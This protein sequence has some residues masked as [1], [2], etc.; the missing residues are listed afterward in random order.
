MGTHSGAQFCKWCLAPV[1]G[2]VTLGLQLVNEFDPV[3]GDI[4]T[5]DDSV[6]ELA[7]DRAFDAL[8]AVPA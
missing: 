7:S 4:Y 3:G 5:L 2:L 8:G 6:N 1:L